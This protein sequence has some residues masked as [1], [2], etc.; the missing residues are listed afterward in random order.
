M[1]AGKEQSLD[2]NTKTHKI[3]LWGWGNN[4]VIRLNNPDGKRL[5]ETRLEI[6]T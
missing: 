3:K 5:E 1:T 2:A 6:K 4:T